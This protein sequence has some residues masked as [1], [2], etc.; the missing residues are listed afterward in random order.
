MSHIRLQT[1]HG[2]VLDMQGHPLAG[3]TVTAMVDANSQQARQV[4][5]VT[6]ADGRYLLEQLP[7]GKSVSLLSVEAPG[8]CRPLAGKLPSSSADTIADVSMIACTARVQGKVC[9]TDGKPVPG[10]TV[11]SAEA[12]LEQRAVTDAAG[13]FTLTGQPEGQ[14]HLIAATP[15]GGGVAACTAP[16]ANVLISYAAGL[17]AQPCDVPLAI[18]LLDADSRQPAAQRLFNRAETIRAIADIDFDSATKLAMTGDEPL[19]QGL[20]AYL[21]ARQ[22]Q[23]NPANIEDN[24]IQLNLLTDANCKLY[25]T[26]EMGIA[27]ARSDPELAE[28]LYAI[29]KPI[30][31]HARHNQAGFTNIA[32]L[33]LFGDISLCTIALAGQLQKTADV[34]AMLAQVK[35][36]VGQGPNARL[37]D[38]VFAAAGEVSPEFV[39]K[40]YD[41]CY[42][43][44]GSDWDKSENLLTALTSMAQ[45]DP[46]AA[47]RLINM[48]DARGCDN[49]KQFDI[50]PLI[51]TLSK[52]DPNAALALAKTL[53]EGWLQTN[54]LWETAAF[55][56]KQTAIPLVQ[57]V[58]SSGIALRSI[59][60]DIA[61]AIDPQFGKALFAQYK[62]QFQA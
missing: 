43:Q 17:V 50:L 1:V 29:A 46:P 19:S 22:A 36:D 31:D 56:P 18:K 53:P 33:G 42:D 45:H 47:Q 4:T 24:L 14:L 2:R 27:V 35:T 62:Q 60:M 7:A 40:V 32:G 13:A 57:N 51:Q 54:V 39:L 21:L 6:C 23:A 3:V 34:N 5:A 30:Y 58:A 8:Y 11:V 9:A 38:A 61:S 55:Q 41:Y 48:L 52:Q 10:A 20:R 15:I 49:W 59:D 25:A 12:G 37:L 16:A 26:V 28:Q 44:S